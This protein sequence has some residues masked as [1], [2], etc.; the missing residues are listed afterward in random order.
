MVIP[1]NVCADHIATLFSGQQQPRH[2][3]AVRHQ[4][5][6]YR[7]RCEDY[8]RQIEIGGVVQSV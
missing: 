1:M 8:R 5:G 7:H 2:H 4:R 3:A 6:F